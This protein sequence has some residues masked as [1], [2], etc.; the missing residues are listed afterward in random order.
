MIRSTIFFQLLDTPFL[1]SVPRR[2]WVC[3]RA[4]AEAF[5]T[6]GDE[7]AVTLV[8]GCPHVKASLRRYF[9]RVSAHVK[10]KLA[11]MLA[12]I[13]ELAANIVLWRRFFTAL[14]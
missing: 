10:C 2:A 5:N 9:T 3:G 12:T 1:P 7:C 13:R 8:R 6:Q 4:F 14:P 11:T